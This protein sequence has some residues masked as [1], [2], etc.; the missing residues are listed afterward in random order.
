MGFFSHVISI[1][2]KKPEIL[3]VTE[4]GQTV[5][6]YEMIGG[7]FQV[8]AG[9]PERLFEKLADETVQDT[10]YVDTFIIHHSSFTMSSVLLEQLISRFYLSPSPGEHEYFK[11]WQ[12]SIQTK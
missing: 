7:K 3:K 10:H 8:I 6:L 2:A 4:N 1:G 5:L 11:K 12:F 9:T